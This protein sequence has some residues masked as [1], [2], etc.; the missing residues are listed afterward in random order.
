MFLLCTCDVLGLDNFL[1]EECI[2]FNEA[3]GNLILA[4]M[5]RLKPPICV[6]AHN[7]EIFDFPLF[8]SEMVLKANVV[9]TVSWCQLF[10]LNILSYSFFSWRIS[11]TVSVT[12]EKMH[13]LYTTQLPAPEHKSK[14]GTLWDPI[15]FEKNFFS[16]SGNKH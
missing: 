13:P 11:K 4:F 12:L 10:C 6:V 15:Y 2:S 14:S 3:T 1:L 5:R 7:G 9:S 16:S 8:R